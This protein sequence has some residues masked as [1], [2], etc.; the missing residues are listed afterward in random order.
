LVIHHWT[1][2]PSRS[3]YWNDHPRPFTWTKA[4][5]ILAN[6]QRAKTSYPCWLIRHDVTQ[7]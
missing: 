5:D 7:F 4:D 1:D 3:D 6:I 2:H